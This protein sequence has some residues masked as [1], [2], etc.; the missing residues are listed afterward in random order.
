MNS[1]CHPTLLRESLSIRV[2]G[3]ALSLLVLMGVFY[4]TTLLQL[5]T[6]VVRREDSSHGLF[7]P[8]LSLYFVWDKRLKLREI[9]PNYE[10]AIGLG[11]VAGGLLLFWLTRVSGYFFLECLSFFVVLCGLV[12]CFL[13]REIFKRI[14]FPI[15]FLIFMIP[16]PEQLYGNLADWVRQG[17]MTGSMQI[18]KLI[19][20]PVLRQDLIIQLPNITLS[21]NIGCSGIRY[22]LSY[23]VFGIAYAYLYRTSTSQRVLLVCLTI[24]LS[25]L[26]STLRLTFIALLAYYIGP[27]MAEYWPHVITSWAVFFM[28]LAFFI[29]LD[30]GVLV[31]RGRE[32]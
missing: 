4:S 30:Q 8:L 29:A 26:A 27:R 25:L 15:F 21:I 19:G 17:A 32:S 2:L 7:V 13:G 10:A 9:Q 1:N 24:P 5:L 11:V 14:V 28:V 6:A 16:I 31:R 18:L 3:L 22:L 12:L 23:F 20:V